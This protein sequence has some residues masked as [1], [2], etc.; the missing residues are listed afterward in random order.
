MNYIKRMESENKVL[1]D[2]LAAIRIELTD[3][4]RY[5]TSEKFREDST[6]QVRDVLNRLQ[7][8]KSESIVS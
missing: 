6:V 8:A 1:W 2:Q 4:E 5:L 3:L 7:T